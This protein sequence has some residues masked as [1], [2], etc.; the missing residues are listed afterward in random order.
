[1]NFRKLFGREKEEEEEAYQDYTLDTMKKGYMVDY[2]LQTWVVTG[3]TTYDYDGFLTQEWEL[4]GGDE[5]RFLEREEEDGEVEWTLTRRIEINQ[6]EE[7]VIDAILEDGD[8]PEDITFAKVRYRG[9]GSGA[10]IMRPEGEGEGREFIEWSYEAEG[11]Q[12][13]S[14]SQWGERD[15]SAYAG[16]VVQEYQF[17]DI[18]PGGQE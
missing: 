1:M 11:D 17:T 5:V 8:P 12:V 4:R 3:Y 15:F 9:A 13:L 2:D 6:I 14:I 10:G 18:L 16:I 7:K